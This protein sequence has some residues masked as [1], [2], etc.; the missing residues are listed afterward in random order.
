MVS[1]REL[2]RGLFVVLRTLAT[3]YGITFPAVNVNTATDDDLKRLYKKLVVKV[4]P[5]KGGN[6]ED[7]RKLKEAYDRW[8]H[9]PQRG[10]RQ[11][12][13]QSAH[14][15]A[16]DTG[17]VHEGGSDFAGIFPNDCKN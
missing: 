3:R 7:F 13:S 16:A 1:K 12:S 17:L 15:D 10:G 9:P 11:Q 4:H 2:F 6:A 5:D 14:G 8:T